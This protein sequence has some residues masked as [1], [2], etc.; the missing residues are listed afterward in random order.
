LT[1]AALAKEVACGQSTI[2]M[3]EKGAFN[4]SPMLWARIKRVLEAGSQIKIPIASSMKLVLPE[5]PFLTFPGQLPIRVETWARPDYSGDFLSI[6]HLSSDQAILVVMDVA[7]HAPNV[8]GKRLYVQGWLRGWFSSQSTTPRLQSVVQA[9][10]EEL[11]ITGIQAG[12]FMAVLTLDR[13]L[14]HTV[15]YEAVACGFPSPLLITGPPFRTVESAVLNAP[16][17]LDHGSVQTTRIERLSCPFR[18]VLASDGLLSRL[19]GGS[20]FEGIKFLRKW[21]TGRDRNQPLKTRLAAELEAVDDE[22]LGLLEWNGW[23][24]EMDFDVQ[25]Q[26]EYHRAAVFLDSRMRNTLGDATAK[27]FQQALAEAVNNAWRHGYA[28]QNGRLLIRFREEAGIFRT[29]IEDEGKNGVTEKELRKEH[30]GFAVMQTNCSDVQVRN[31][32]EQGTVVE[33]INEKPPE[34]G[35]KN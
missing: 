30:S 2:S 6:Q 18:L 15:S 26:A 32:R 13:S 27:G 20:E 21:Q 31:G 10:S 35:G 1:Q 9:V 28:G 12:A 22:F 33:L 4:P 17:P 8:I 29:E 19:G 34:P 16:L 24:R 5:M 3:I 23:D 7:G 25:D 14:R 11:K